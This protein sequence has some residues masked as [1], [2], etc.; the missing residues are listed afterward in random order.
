MRPFF[1][2]NGSKKFQT[3]LCKISNV[4]KITMF[5]FRSRMSV[6]FYLSLIKHY[7]I[8]CYPFHTSISLEGIAPI[9]NL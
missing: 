1:K 4:E 6:K 5:V 8:Y 7:I 9:L 2:K 3:P